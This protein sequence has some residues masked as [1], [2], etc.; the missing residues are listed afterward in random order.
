MSPRPSSFRFELGL[1]LSLALLLGGCGSLEYYAQSVGGQ[2]DVVAASLPLEEV[3]E[4]PETPVAVR[5]K[6]QVL[7]SIRR[8]AVTELALPESDSYRHYADLR[9]EAMVW[10]V[11]AAPADSL[12]PRSWC[13]PVLGCMSYRGYFDQDAALT[14]AEGLAAA[15]WDTAVE[16]VPAYST[17]GW[18]SD[19]LPSTVISWP[20]ADIAGLVFHELAHELLY[21]DGDSGFNEAY[22]T[23]VEKE[24][25]NRWLLQSGTREQRERWVLRER[26]R[27]EF[28]QL[29]SVTRDRLGDLYATPIGREAILERKTEILEMLREE[30]RALKASWGGYTGYDRW[31]QR[32]LNNAHLA[33]VSTYHA[34]VPAFREILR[35]SDGDMAVFH[36]E[37]AAIGALAPAQRKARMEQ[38]LSV[39]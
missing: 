8:F 14:Y 38:L 25:V 23:L 12:R 5:D 20:L 30:Y 29:L 21:V 6:L 35:Q 37:C 10:N 11:V 32:P 3:L 26:R 17:L 16:P 27:R 1:L 31:M 15:G 7:P 4:D 13:Y 39:D 22:A 33:S 9:R 19:P 2:L 24:G 34:M 28:L 18:F 36:R